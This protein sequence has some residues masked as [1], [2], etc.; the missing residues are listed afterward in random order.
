MSAAFF[1][2][3]STRRSLIHCGRRILRKPRTGPET[4]CER[5]QN[6]QTNRVPC[7]FG[8]LSTITAQ[9][10]RHNRNITCGAGFSFEIFPTGFAGAFAA[11]LAG[12]RE[13]A[14]RG[15]TV[16]RVARRDDRVAA[17]RPSIPRRAGFVILLAA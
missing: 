13:V 2:Y 12:R 15:R 7:A 1:L 11:G 6:G 4:R 14:F 8:I 17:I 5:G 16:R 9:P 10:L 3:S